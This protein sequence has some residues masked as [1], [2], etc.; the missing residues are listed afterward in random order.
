MASISNQRLFFNSVTRGAA[1]LDKLYV[2]FFLIILNGHYLFA[3]SL[4]C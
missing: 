1:F 2:I 3:I 4:I